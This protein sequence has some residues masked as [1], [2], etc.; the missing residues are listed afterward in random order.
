M[1]L[2]LTAPRYRFIQTSPKQEHTMADSNSTM[3][4]P[5]HDAELATAIVA[6][7]DAHA[8][9][10]PLSPLLKSW[11]EGGQNAHHLRAR[12]YNVLLALIE[13]YGGRMPAFE[14]PARTPADTEGAAAGVSSEAGGHTDA[15]NVGHSS[16]KRRRESTD[17]SPSPSARLGKKDGLKAKTEGEGSMLLGNKPPSS[18]TFAAPSTLTSQQR[19]SPPMWKLQAHFLRPNESDDDD[20]DKDEDEDPAAGPTTPKRSGRGRYPPR[21]CTQGQPMYSPAQFGLSNL[22]LGLDSD[23][24]SSSDSDDGGEGDVQQAEENMDVQPSAMAEEQHA[25]SALGDAAER[26]P[27]AGGQHL[28]RESCQK[29]TRQAEPVK[30]E[31]EA[32]S[33]YVDSD[34]ESSGS[35]VIEV[36]PW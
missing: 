1:I 33:T 20:D 30:V 23:S 11:T 12:T 36:E 8:D 27:D 26:Q 29:E 4:G 13:R 16:P 17:S 22:E 9:E 3:W 19:E 15:A 35:S 14:L 2:S 28:P 25:E 10:L 6:F 31:P 21:R 34:P 5:Q 7:V 18:E 32:G 24:T